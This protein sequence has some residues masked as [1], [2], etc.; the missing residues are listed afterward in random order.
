[1]FKAFALLFVGI[2]ILAP[3][4]NSQAQNNPALATDLKLLAAVDHAT[5]E[6]DTTPTAFQQGLEEFNK[7]TQEVQQIGEKIVP[8]VLENKTGDQL[9]KLIEEEAARQGL[10][11]GLMSGLMLL[12][13]IISDLLLHPILTIVLILMT[14]GLAV[15]VFL[16]V[17]RI[18]QEEFA[19]LVRL[20]SLTLLYLLLYIDLLLI[21]YE[22]R[23]I[24][25]IF[26]RLDKDIL[27][28][29]VASVISYIAGR[30]A[31]RKLFEEKVL[32]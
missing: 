11:T 1:M 6:N 12:Y 16:I 2:M 31:S 10:L 28:V 18:R 14:L 32:P 29:T 8:N 24:T 25:G 21:I 4:T 23:R 9:K 19:L 17:W 7:K 20:V 15:L 3:I 5:Q 30:Y 13:S 27:L 22:E 26:F